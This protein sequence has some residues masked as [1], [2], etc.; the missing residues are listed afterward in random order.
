[1]LS[2]ARIFRVRWSTLLTSG[3]GY[4]EQAGGVLPSLAA[5]I[6]PIYSPE[7][8]R[9]IAKKGFARIANVKKQF[10]A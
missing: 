1:M 7:R 8:V 9:G 2:G 5:S 6:G 10:L 4:C 3:L